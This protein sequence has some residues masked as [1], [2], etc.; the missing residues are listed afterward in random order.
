MIAAKR[1]A[2]GDDVL[3]NLLNAE[4]SEGEIEGLTLTLLSLGRDSV[5]YM[6][7]TSTVALLR[8]PDHCELLRSDPALMP[9]AI[10]EFMHYGA[11]S[12]TLFPRTALENIKLGDSFF[13]KDESLSVSPVADNRDERRFP[14]PETFD[15]T[16]DAFGRLG[17]GHGIHGCVGQQLARL[18]MRQALSILL[19]EL[20]GLHLVFAEQT[21]PLPF[22]HP[23]ATYEAGA[24]IVGW[25]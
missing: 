9:G 24:V 13:A 18:E 14:D 1:A 7:A 25:T 22:A 6:I 17:F 19:H 10:E 3:S 8:H 20:P 4:L 21:T 5:A 12:L 2:P 11:M 15:I 23:V 16:R